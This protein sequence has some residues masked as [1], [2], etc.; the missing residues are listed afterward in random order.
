LPKISVISG[1][2]S[3]TNRYVYETYQSLL[4]QT[5][6]DWEWCVVVNNG[7][8]MPLSAQMDSRVHIRDSSSRKVGEIKRRACALASAPYVVELDSDD[9]LVPDALQRI[10]ETF[11]A[12][13]AVDFVYSDFAEF[14]DD[15]TWV[16]AKSFVYSPQF[17]WKSYPFEHRGQQLHAMLAPPATPQNVRRVLWAPNHVRA[18]KASTYWAIGGHD[19][20]MAVLDD[21]DLVLQFVTRGKRLQKIDRCL[22]LYRRHS[23]N[24]VGTRN[25]EIQEAANQVYWRYCWK[26]AELSGRVWTG[27]DL[28]CADQ[29]R[30]GEWL[31]LLCSKEAWGKL[32]RFTGQFH[33]SNIH[34]RG[35]SVEAHLIRLG[36]GYEPMG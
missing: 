4:D 7:G 25:Q 5:E 17:G 13:P 18:W 8:V 20:G 34:D 33:A 15:G 22:Y 21:H 35:A 32:P 6:K 28:Q 12:E 16:P 26:L 3:G 31:F 23:Q 9:F 29:M 2:Y 30:P 19:P 11:N 27:A 24:T 14:I 36:E 10:L 1:V